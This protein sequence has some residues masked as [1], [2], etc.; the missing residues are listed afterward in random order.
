[1][2]MKRMTMK[3]MKEGEEEEQNE[4]KEETVT[5]QL[6][7]VATAL[8]LSSLICQRLLHLPLFL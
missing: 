8:D 7:Q 2:K 3:K 6:G 1:M 4:G 5:F